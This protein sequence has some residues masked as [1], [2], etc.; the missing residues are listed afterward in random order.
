[1]L[2]VHQH[3]ARA[4]LVD[5]LDVSLD[6]LVVGRGP[7]RDALL[8]EL[9]IGLHRKLRARIGR[10][11][12]MIIAVGANRPDAET[13]PLVA[14]RQEHGLALEGVSPT[15]AAALHGV[16]DVDVPAVADEVVEP[17]GLS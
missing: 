13:L 16:G 6:D 3:D 10:A 17:A 5:Q 11:L 15:G 14:D 12:G 9:I 7:A 8:E 4:D 1:G 2:A